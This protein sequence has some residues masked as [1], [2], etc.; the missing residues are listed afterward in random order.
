M[1]RLQLAYAPEDL[2]SRV[3]ANGGLDVS[4]ESRQELPIS[5]SDF[6]HEKEVFELSGG[7]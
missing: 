2:W 3:Q 6:L 4:G 1:G 5:S 7:N